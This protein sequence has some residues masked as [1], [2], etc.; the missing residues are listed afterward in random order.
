VWSWY[1]S[2]INQRALLLFGLSAISGLAVNQ[3]YYRFSDLQVN[4]GALFSGQFFLA[5]ASSLAS[6]GSALTLVYLP[7]FFV[8]PMGIL[9]FLFS[10]PWRWWITALAGLAVA[11]GINRR[12]GRIILVVLLSFAALIAPYILRL[13]LM[14]PGVFYSPE[15]ILSGRVFYIPFLL[16][17]L[18]FGMAASKIESI[19]RRWTGLMVFLGGLSYL[20]AILFTYQPSDFLGL[21]VMKNGPAGLLVPPE[22]WNPYHSITPA[23]L[24][25]VLLAILIALTIRFIFAKRRLISKIIRSPIR[26]NRHPHPPE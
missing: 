23:G 21:N 19:G 10:E 24:G 4:P 7:S 26:A 15:Y 6:F 11:F 17:A 13:F 9:Q 8:H 1:K 14:P 16:L 2:K 18:G 5:A 25:W 3:W 20:W 12:N 22:N